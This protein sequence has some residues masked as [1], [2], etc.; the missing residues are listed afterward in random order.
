MEPFSESQV[1]HPCSDLQI[2]EIHQAVQSKKHIGYL[3][4]LQA[5]T[6]EDV[7]DSKY[8]GLKAV[9]RINLV[10]RGE[11]KAMFFGKV[12]S[13]DIHAEDV[14]SKKAQA[15]DGVGDDESP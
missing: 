14:V 10:Q 8:L 11:S 2:K 12:L 5:C 4:V 1:E 15:P 9:T 13:R 7:V 6:N 3:D